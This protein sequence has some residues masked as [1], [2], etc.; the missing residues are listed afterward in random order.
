[1]NSSVC[2]VVVTYNRKNLLIECLE[3]L[4][5]QTRPVQGIYLI[6]NASTDETPELLL[7]KGYISEL[8][9]QNLREP[10]EKES[11]ISNFTDGNIINLHYVRMH[12]N[13]GGAGG[14]YE[15]VK[16]GYE[17]GYDWLWLMDDDA[18]P[19]EN[20]LEKL[21]TYDK[22]DILCM[23][24]LVINKESNKVQNYHHKDFNFYMLDI[25]IL[26]KTNIEDYQDKVFSIK[27]N[28][29]VGPLIRRR[30]VDLAGFPDPELF[31]WGDDTDYTYRIYRK[32]KIILVGSAIM[33]HKDNPVVQ[34]YINRNQLR[35]IYYG[36]RNKIRFIKLY[37]KY[38]FLA[39]VY[40][41]YKAIKVSL[42]LLIK[43]KI[44]DNFNFLLPIKGIKDGFM[45]NT[46]KT[47]G[48]RG[49][50]DVK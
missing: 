18:E 1:M 45:N 10:W 44:V 6:D 3:A 7:E 26:S 37:S 34:E 4:R 13:T 15:G 39:Y 43:Y 40:F 33:L 29:F 38:N 41:S 22:F 14:F 5:R 2:A 24:P 48:F 47:K 35:K 16:R 17:K 30:T 42:S 36:F 8:P 11:G 28:A 21:L 27:A 23:C 49:K 25:P 31:I 32:G 46:G 19:K 9:P 50:E 12:E 20:T